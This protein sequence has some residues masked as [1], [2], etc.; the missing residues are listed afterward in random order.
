LPI[1]VSYSKNPLKRRILRGYPECESENPARLLL[2]TSIPYLLIIGKSNA[3]RGYPFAKKY[4]AVQFRRAMGYVTSKDK[5][6]GREPEIVAMRDQK[7]KDAKEQRKLRWQAE[8]HLDTASI[9]SKIFHSCTHE[10][11]TAKIPY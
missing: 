5:L 3:I 11:N 7:L 2:P 9:N 8:R 10:L 6:L 1:P 4:D